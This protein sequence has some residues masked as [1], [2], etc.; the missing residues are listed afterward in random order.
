MKINTAR[1]SPD[2]CECEIE[3]SWDEDL[4]QDGRT[5]TISFVNKSC[6]YHRNLL[7]NSTVTY[8]CIIDENQKKN[9]SLQTAL[10]NAADK[11]ADTFV[12]P[13]GVQYYTLKNGI[14]FS[15][16]FSGTAPNRIL[17]IQFVGTSLTQNQKNSIQNKLNQIF[18]TGNVVIN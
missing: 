1:W 5:T 17:T 13:E 6:Q 15:F 11:L 3:Y 2:T 16:S 18:G 4:P 14:V 8:S 7:P 10:E 12:N 9:K